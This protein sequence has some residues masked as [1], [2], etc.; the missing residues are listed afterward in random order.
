M[1][2][3]SDSALRVLDDRGRLCW[4]KRLPPLHP[5]YRGEVLDKTLV[6][7][8]DGD[9]RREVLLNTLPE[10]L[11]AE[12]GRLTCFEQDGRQRWQ[13]RLGSA[14]KFGSRFFE[15]S[16][17]GRHLRLVR[18]AG[19][20]YVLTVANH[21]LWYPSQTA[22]RD[23]HTGRVVE[24]YW[25]P[26][27]VHHCLVR[28]LDGDGAPE[29]LL[30]AINNPGDGIGHAA[31]ARLSLPFSRSARLDHDSRYPP[32]TGGGEAAYALLPVPDVVRVAGLLPLLSDLHVSAAGRVVVQAIL[33]ENSAIVY[34][35][36]RDLNIADVRF[37]DSFAAIHDRFFKQRL[38]DHPLSPGEMRALGRV[39]RFNAAPDGNAPW[40]AGF[41]RY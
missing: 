3:L 4:E 23:P 25:H 39:A 32:V 27:A 29:L 28:D 22:M 17:R 13:V 35:L 20:P 36:N 40:L 31:V 6:G 11:A 15:H 19:R 30:G 1:A 24:E 12:G 2:E 26:G 37:S 33:P 10:N 41:W 7:D 8:I 5:T 21:Y 18:A 34:S 38:L 9:G 14:R 16:Y